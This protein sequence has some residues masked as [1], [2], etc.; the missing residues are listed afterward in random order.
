MLIHL[1]QLGCHVG[2]A[3]IE[4]VA[5]VVHAQVMSNQHIPSRAGLG[6]PWQHMLQGQAHT[7]LPPST[8]QELSSRSKS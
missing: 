4:G 7:A 8:A 3:D 5:R 6:D 1:K 2:A